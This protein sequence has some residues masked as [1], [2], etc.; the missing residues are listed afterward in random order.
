MLLVLITIFLILFTI[1]IKINLKVFL[2]FKDKKIFF[3]SDVYRF[4]K[5]S[6][7]FID[8]TNNRL[9]LRLKNKKSS[10]LKYKDMLPDKV[11]TDF[12]LHFDLINF[13]SA[14]LF[15]GEFNE[16]KAF[17]CIFL[18]SLSKIAYQVLKGQKP[19]LKFR[20]DVFLL[21]EDEPSGLMTNV[22]AVTNAFAIT[23]IFIKKLYGGIYN[24]VKGKIK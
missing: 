3:T 22:V 2:G 21:E 6:S 19:Y 5:I 7:G 23:E 1:P 20:N 14:I 12:I 4:I 17:S 10:C 8:F 24:Y 18:N 11:K 15:G 9:I 13:H 16:F